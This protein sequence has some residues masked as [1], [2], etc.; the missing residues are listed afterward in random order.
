M[1]SL[2][3]LFCY[4]ILKD[5]E[6]ENMFCKNC[7]APLKEGAKFC[8]KCGVAA[9]T[10]LD[11]PQ[12]ELAV[13]VTVEP[14]EKQSIEL[15]CADCGTPLKNGAT[16]CPNC[17]I[18]VETGNTDSTVIVNASVVQEAEPETPDSETVF[19]E[20]PQD[21]D[22]A[23]NSMVPIPTEKID[24]DEKII[25]QITSV[26]E[27][28]TQERN[29]SD[30]ENR[31]N[32]DRLKKTKNGLIAA[33]VIGVT[34]IIIAIGVG[35]NQYI[36]IKSLRSENLWL[37]SNL[38]PINITSIKTGNRNNGQW[39]TRPGGTLYSSQMRYLELEIT[40]N[41]IINEEITFYIKILQPN[42]NL[43]YNPNISPNG[44]TY[45]NTVRVNRGDNQTLSLSGWGNGSNST[46]R[47]GEWTVEVWY[48]NVCLI[49]EKVLIQ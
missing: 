10:A 22:A 30:E 29:Q 36:S 38:L 44:Y 47:T 20:D 21:T 9:V 41:S 25:S 27:R 1:V 48:K 46:Y 17:G 40:Y 37:E 11:I 45:A 13:P 6:K 4:R 7:G 26:I 19:Q 42:G 43:N 14:V 49:S 32:M 12:P 8:P 35:Y 39:I 23:P 31:K 28:L 24:N 34:C 3:V 2:F 5:K 33:I 18:K 15:K 16:F